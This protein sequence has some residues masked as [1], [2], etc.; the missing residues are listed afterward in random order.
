MIDESVISYAVKFQGALTSFQRD[1]VSADDFENEFRSIWR[2]LVRAKQ[3]HG[4]VPSRQ[5]VKTRFPDLYMPVMRE[6]DY[7]HLLSQLRQRKKHKDFA[8]ALTKAAGMATSYEEVDDAIQVLQGDLNQLS[9]RNGKSH[10]VNLFEK[11]TTNRMIREMRKKRI[12]G[13]FE[14]NILTGLKRFDDECGGLTPQQ[15]VVI[16]GR[17]SIGKS[18]LDL[19]FVAQ[20]VMLGKTVMLYPLEM[21]LFDTACR[22]YT[23]F[24]QSMFGMRGTLRNRELK[25]GRV[26]SRMVREFLTTLEDQLPGR[27]I[28]ADMG[29]LS[30]PYTAERIE[31]EVE[32]YKP[33]MFWVDYLTLMKPPPSAKGAGDWQSVRALSNS[34]KGIA[35]RQNV[36]GGCSAQVNREALRVRQFLP[37]LEHIAYG[38]S[39]GQDA[40]VVFSINRKQKD[41]LYYSVVKNRHGEEIG[42]E[43]GIRLVFDVDRGLVHEAGEPESDAEN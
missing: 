13:T 35:V 24:T 11:E 6:Q 38:D 16:I 37:R 18:W 30:D 21:T 10:L 32:L 43:K 4:N 42:G 20:A 1:G 26:N 14:S 33:D 7:S 9:T 41:E 36:V 22:L 31:A 40:D 8:A 27:I 23:L 29:N 3:E 17:T 12:G 28:I 5:I 2:Y 34:I 19:L 15:M 25:A 39:I